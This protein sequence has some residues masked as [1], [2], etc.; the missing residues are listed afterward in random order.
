MWPWQKSGVE[1]DDTL[2]PVSDLY[3][4]VT[5][6][7][8]KLI[9]APRDQYAQRFSKV[10]DG[11]DESAARAKSDKD[12]SSLAK[13][14]ETAVDRFAEAQRECVEHVISDLDS[15]LRELLGVLDGS[16]LHGQ[17][18]I[19]HASSVT[20]R[21]AAASDLS[22]MNEMRSALKQEVRILALAMKGYRDSSNATLNAYQKELELMRER[23]D[24][25]QESARTDGLTHL[26]NRVSHE[27]YLNAIIKKSESGSEYSLAIIDLDG[28]KA[29]NDTYGH[30]AGDAA[31]TDFAEKLKK[32]I[33]TNGFV[34][35][36]G[37]DEFS[38]VANFGARRLSE[39]LESFRAKLLS[40]VTK[41]E[42][43]EL[44]FGLSFGVSEVKVQSN[45]ADLMSQADDEMYRYKR[46]NKRSAA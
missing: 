4:G 37:G 19:D 45:F 41:Y 44:S 32:A 27:F 16:L 12:F 1:Q 43:W 20:S 8:R 11:L 17:E 25:A 6:G 13:E 5:K 2:N 3:C 36:L 14:H 30:Q 34:A 24:A 39:F 10:L 21:L 38:V 22:S 7:L 28:F 18:F 26:P 42:K 9:L 23:L 33:G 35:R 15:S 40:E 31:L 46:K 29:I